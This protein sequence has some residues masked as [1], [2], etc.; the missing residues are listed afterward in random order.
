MPLIYNGQM[1]PAAQAQTDRILVATIALTVVL[2]V[3]GWAFGQYGPVLIANDK[4]FSIL[5][6]NAGFFGYDGLQHLL[7][8]F[9]IGTFIIFLAR[10]FPAHNVLHAKFWRSFLVIVALVVLVSFVWE[11][12]E[13]LSDQ[14]SIRILHENILVPNNMEQ[15]S[16]IDTMGDMSFS[17]VG[18]MLA[19]AAFRSK[20]RVKETGQ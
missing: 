7:S 4:C 3:I 5:R 8:G 9:G 19:I 13:M 15:P 14:F 10:L 11:M 6:C 2:F 16:N 18:G 1:Q 12:G 17:L 20:V